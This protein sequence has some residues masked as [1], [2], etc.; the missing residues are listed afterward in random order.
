MIINN[1]IYVDAK[2]LT[3]VIPTYN[4]EER[5]IKELKS[6]FLQPEY[7]NIEIVILDNHSNYNITHSLVQNFSPEEL[8]N[9]ELV[10]NPF[11][12][13]GEGNLSNSFK[14]CK[15][16]YMWLLG[17]DDETLNDSIKTILL[18]IENNKD[19]AVFKYSINNFIL[20]EDKFITNISEF[21]NYYKNGIHTSGTMIFVSN[22]IFNMEL[23]EPFIQN[24]FTPFNLF[25]LIITILFTNTIKIKYCPQSIVN[26]IPPNPGSEWN[27][28]SMLLKMATFDKFLISILYKDNYAFTKRQ[29]IELSTLIVRDF[30]RI[31]LIID[32]FKLDNRWKRSYIYNKIFFDVL[33]HDT[34]HH[35]IYFFLFHFLNFINI[36]YVHL[37]KIK[38]KAKNI[39]KR[40]K[41]KNI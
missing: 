20:E 6:I 12:I 27:F 23:L 32:L 39:L 24:A 5:L 33:I 25:M 26:Y 36:D 17:D 18:G 11:N 4:R 21:I 40:F 14:F 31:K 7:K 29:I 8:L 2:L 9:I 16:K 19:I 38:Q 1:H 41:A 10:I 22:N 35:W 30:P 34:E 13:G 3:I 15:T 28:I 37:S